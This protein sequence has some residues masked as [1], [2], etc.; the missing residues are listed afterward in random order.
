MRTPYDDLVSEILADLNFEF[1]DGTMTEEEMGATLKSLSSSIMRS[2]WKY[3]EEYK[4]D[5]NGRLIFEYGM[6]KHLFNGPVDEQ[7]SE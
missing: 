6:L 5:H 3:V 1:N 4:I 2:C 7:I